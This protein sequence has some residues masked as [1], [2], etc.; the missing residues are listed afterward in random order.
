MTLNSLLRMKKLVAL[1][2]QIEL[3]FGN[4]GEGKT[5]V[6]GEKPLGTR[7]RTNKKLNPHIYDAK[8][9]NQAR[10]TLVG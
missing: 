8:S 5:R 7:T 1:R 9:G 3:E 6:P 4:V 2:F 10:A